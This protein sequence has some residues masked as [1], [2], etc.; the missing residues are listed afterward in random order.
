MHGLILFLLLFGFGCV[1]KNS[2]DKICDQKSRGFIIASIFYAQRNEA[3]CYNGASRVGSNSNFNSAPPVILTSGGSI[4][5]GTKTYTSISFNWPAATSSG[6][7]SYRVYASIVNTWS[8]LAEVEANGTMF[9]D[10]TPNITSITVPNLIA[11]QFYRF[12][13]I[14]RDSTGTKILY[15]HFC[16]QMDPNVTGTLTCK[17]ELTGVV[18]TYAGSCGAAGAFTTGA[19]FPTARYF[20]N[21]GM[22]FLNGKLYIADATNYRIRVIDM[23]TSID[24]VLAGGGSNGNMNG[25]GTGASL[26]GGFALTTDGTDLYLMQSNYYN[27]RKINPTSTVVTTFAGNGTSGNMDGIGGAARF[28]SLYSGGFNFSDGALYIGDDNHLI[29]KSTV[30]GA[31]V[32]TVAG[33]TLTGQ[34][35]G[36]A[37]SNQ[38]ASPIIILPYGNILFIPTYSGSTIRRLDLSTSTLSSVGSGFAVNNNKGIAIMGNF[39]YVSGDNDVIYKMSLTDFSK[40]IFAGA[41]STPNTTDGIGTSARFNNPRQMIFI[42]NSMYVADNGNNCIRK[43]D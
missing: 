18:T 43:I 22:V 14:A 28:N 4:T 5:Q 19:I 1:Q 39:M 29:R 21:S 7:V 27:V 11:F 16:V 23:A 17:T 6:I 34:T 8:T 25:T 9:Q 36:S 35:D 12:D 41:L 32:T 30:P 13:V 33:N 15:P 40:V 20:G 37:L 24:S 31:D 10:F 26:G 42:G 2:F 3:Y 38:I